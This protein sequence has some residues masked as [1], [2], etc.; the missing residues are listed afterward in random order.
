LLDGLA[1]VFFL[2]RT[3]AESV[4]D[5]PTLLVGIT[6]SLYARGV[7]DA[8]LAKLRAACRRFAHLDEDGLPAVLQCV[9]TGQDMAVA[10]NTEHPRQRRLSWLGT[11]G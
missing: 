3:L 5:C 7:D 9:T 2:V 6:D 10:K 4:G 11:D 8:A 1:L